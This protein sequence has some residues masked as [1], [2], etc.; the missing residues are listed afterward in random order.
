MTPPNYELFAVRY[1]TRDAKR[2]ANFL[3]GDPHDASM[4]MDY[5]V[6]AARSPERTVIIDTGFTAA[7]A[8]R[9]K[10]TYLRHPVEGLAALGI[11]SAAIRDVVLTHLH[12]DHVGGFES[13]PNATFH[14]QE[15]E[16][17]FSTGRHMCHARFNH[18][19]DVEDIA[20]MIRL[21]F[22]RR[23]V[24]HKGQVELAPGISVH[25][26]GGHTA[27]LQCVRVRT[28]RG[29]VV[30]ASDSSHY[31]E[32]FE[33]NRSFPTVFHVGELIEGYETLRQLADSPDHIV[34]G[35]DP[36]VMAR[37]PAVSE[38]LRDIAVRLDIQPSPASAQ[39]RACRPK[40]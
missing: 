3:G 28:A 24:F 1:A 10:R 40:A 30:I 21:V 38:T 4:P 17:R 39:D 37:Y 2:S 34:P 11:H 5:Y 35:H 33:T 25:R 26:I 20:G 7:A 14:V 18:G 22:S 29:W 12:Y 8:Q 23:V 36:L 6:W 19:Y 32:H 27:G 16:M 15:D 31:Y 9:R 13:F